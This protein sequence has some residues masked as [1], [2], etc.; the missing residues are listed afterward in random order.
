MNQTMDEE[1]VENARMIVDS[2]RAIVPADNSLERVRKVRFEGPGYDRTV[3]TQAGELGLFLMRVSEQAGGLGLGTRETCELARVLGGGLLPEPVLPAIAAGALLQENLPEA[4]MSGAQVITCAWQDEINSL[5]W[6]GGVT[7]GKLSGRKVA[8]QGAAGADLFA[9]VT[10][11]GVAV[12]PREAVTVESA[13]RLD[14]GLLSAVRFNAIEAKLFPCPGAQAVLE[15]ASLAHA[16]YLLGLSERAL[17][18]TL[19][20]LRVRKQFDK[21][22]GSFQALQHRAT[23]MKTGLE[24][25]RAAI[26]ATARRFDSGADALTRARGAARCKLRA[27]ELAM[28]ISREAVQMHGAMGITDE[29]DI[30]LFVRKAMAEANLF[31]APRTLRALLAR[32]LDVEDAA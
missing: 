10:G 7:D 21:P 13:D 19:D 14:G 20:Y 24:L 16:A 27:T 6:D 2:A 29:A 1:W 18:I 11:Q 9:V 31:G 3:M 22:I 17:E 26:F 25:S 23:E 12:L 4:A 30:G 15:D 5:G 28:L 8:V 32:M